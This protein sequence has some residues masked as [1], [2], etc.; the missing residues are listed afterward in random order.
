MRPLA[1]RHLILRS[2]DRYLK[3]AT[4]SIVSATG[5]LPRN[6]KT[7]PTGRLSSMDL[8]TAFL[9]IPA[10][11]A[12]NNGITNQTGTALMKKHVGQPALWSVTNKVIQELSIASRGRKGKTD[13]T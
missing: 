13:S 11:E 1:T 2:S 6:I 8:P 3:K 5:H 12:W 10:H 7:R 9:K 4:V